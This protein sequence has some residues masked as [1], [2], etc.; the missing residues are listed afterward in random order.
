MAQAHGLEVRTVTCDW[1]HGVEIAQVKAAL[2]D[3]SKHA[4]KAICVVHN[5]T[6]TG[7]AAA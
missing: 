6:A 3:D 7:D 5:E 4:I 2:A 1:R